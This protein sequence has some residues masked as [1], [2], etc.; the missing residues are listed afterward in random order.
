LKA[1]GRLEPAETG[2]APASS[3]K[4][5]A[6]FFLRSLYATI[7]SAPMIME[8]PTPTTTPM[9][10]FFVLLE[11]PPPSPSSEV[12]SSLRL[13]GVETM[14]EASDVYP[15]DVVGVPEI[16]MT[17][18]TSRTLVV[19]MRVVEAVG[20]SVVLVSLSSSLSSLGGEV[21]DVDVVD[22]VGSSSSSSGGG[23]G[24]LVVVLLVEVDVVDVTGGGSGISVVEVGGGCLSVVLVV[25]GGGGS[26][27]SVELPSSC[28]FSR[29][30]PTTS[31]ITLAEDTLTNIHS[32]K[33][34]RNKRVNFLFI[35]YDVLLR[36]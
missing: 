32:A 2:D 10:V 13:V 16:V 14:T 25:G 4:P 3:P 24:G 30:I 19:V 5:P 33:V 15:I 8:P 18:V 12:P 31:S 17:T 11:M 27:G 29:T 9:I 6:V 1:S 21:V 20:S 26:S 34:N 28:R 22:V 36:A 7:A 23:G 35:V